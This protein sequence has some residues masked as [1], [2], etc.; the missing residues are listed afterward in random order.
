VPNMGQN[1]Q[2]SSQTQTQTIPHKHKHKHKQTTSKISEK[3]TLHVSRHRSLANLV[4]SNA[5]G[6]KRFAA[7]AYLI[8]VSRR[9]MPKIRHLGTIKPV[10]P[11][12]KK[13]PS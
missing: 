3:V 5:L 9:E 13:R 12:G 11:S 2:Q 1:I 4:V 8:F 10:V 7:R 6:V